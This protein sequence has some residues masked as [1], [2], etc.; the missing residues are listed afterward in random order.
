M[1][2]VEVEHFARAAEAF[3]NYCRG[4]SVVS[5]S[6]EIRELIALLAELIRRAV[7]LPN[8]ELPS[9]SEASTEVVE[10]ITISVAGAG[11]YWEIFDALEGVDV[12]EVPQAVLGD[13]ADDLT[14]IYRDVTEGLLYWQAGTERGRRE[15]AWSWKLTFES[16]WGEHATGALRALYWCLRNAAIE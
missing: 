8:V 1:Q 16:H 12:A 4:H 9:G 10:P 14:G 15:A 7:L 11:I 2:M 6:S 13:L 5:G 3:R